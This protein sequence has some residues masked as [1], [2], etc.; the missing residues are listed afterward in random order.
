MNSLL[1]DNI[2]YYIFSAVLQME[3]LVNT[4]QIVTAYYMTACILCYM[5]TAVIQIEWLVNTGLQA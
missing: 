4:G 2:S 5:F 1:A 3:W